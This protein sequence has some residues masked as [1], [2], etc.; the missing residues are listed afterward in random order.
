[1]QPGEKTTEFWTIVMAQAL[2]ALLA[3]LAAMSGSNGWAWLRAVL[4]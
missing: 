3:I 2:I 1:M 4:G